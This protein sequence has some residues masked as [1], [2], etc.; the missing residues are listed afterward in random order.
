MGT[1]SVDGVWVRDQVAVSGGRRRQTGS[2]VFGGTVV[3]VET[4]GGEQ[5][6][7]LLQEAQCALRR[8]LLLGQF[9]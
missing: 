7:L 9:T 4:V 5:R 8:E 1:A 2:A 3:D 6:L